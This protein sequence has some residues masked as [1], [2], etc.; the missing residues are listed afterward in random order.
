MNETKSPETD[1]IITFLQRMST[2]YVIRSA[3]WMVTDEDYGAGDE[4]DEGGSQRIRYV[5][6]DCYENDISEDEFDKLPE[7]AEDAIEDEGGN[8][9][10]QEDYTRHCEA[11][12]WREHGVFFTETDAKGHLERNHYHYSKCAHTY[13]KH[14]WRAP[15][16][17]NF[18]LALFKHFGVEPRKGKGTM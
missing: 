3:E 5:N 4:G 18:L 11:R 14:V 17:E 2:Y 16:L 1:T 7:N 13:V 12:I 8:K 9:L 10:S 6:N 15:E